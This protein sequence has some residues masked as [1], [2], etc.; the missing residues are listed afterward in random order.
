MTEVNLNPSQA[1]SSH[2]LARET[3]VA[4]RWEKAALAAFLGLLVPGMGQLY[5]RRPRKAL[6]FALPIPISLVVA[7]Q[8]RVLFS[9]YVMVVFTAA[10]IAWRVFI[11]AE[12]AYTVWTAKKAE[13][14]VHRPRVTYLIAAIMLLIAT[15]YPPSDAFK[16]WTG[17]AAFKVSSA[18]MCPTICLGERIVADM[19]A[20]K[21]K[22]PQRGDVI[23]LA[24]KL[25]SALFVK[26]VIGIPGDIV[27]PGPNGSILVNGK[28]LPPPEVCGNPVEQK[29]DPAESSTF[30]WTRVPE[31]TFFVIG[32]NLGHSFDS[33][34]PEFGPV[35]LDQ[36]QGKP[37]Y[38][39]WSPGHSRISCH[40][41]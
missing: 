15:L 36:I 3:K 24:Y 13:A 6:W 9:F 32:D 11:A 21:S 14:A 19:R 40:T 37:L 16:R 27:E 10:L 41:R 30:E 23:L 28:P 31:G 18:S 4:S 1:P 5:D 17:F 35:V 39:Y 34:I 33:R 20:Y 26:R 38:V 22:S 29:S 12:A 2:Q 8:T 7:A 25:S